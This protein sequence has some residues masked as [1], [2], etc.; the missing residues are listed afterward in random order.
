MILLVFALVDL[1]VIIY[2]DI[3]SENINKYSVLIVVCIGDDVHYSCKSYNCNRRIEQCCIV[4]KSSYTDRINYRVCRIRLSKFFFDF[5]PCC[6]I[7]TY[8]YLYI[9]NIYTIISIVIV[10][11]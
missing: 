9:Y 3:I 6:H 8:K 11:S 7:I 5:N 2:F 1:V 10:M 4:T